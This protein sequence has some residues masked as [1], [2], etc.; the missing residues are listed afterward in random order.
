MAQASEALQRRQRFVG[1]R[2]LEE[3]LGLA[4]SFLARYA[5]GSWSGV[6]AGGDTPAEG[7][8][9]LA[10]SHPLPYYVRGNAVK[11]AL[12]RLAMRLRLRGT[13]PAGGC[14]A[15][16]AEARRHLA[17]CLAS[18]AAAL[19]RFHVELLSLL[20]D[21]ADLRQLATG[22]HGLAP[23]LE[24]YGESHEGRVEATG[25]KAVGCWVTEVLEAHGDVLAA[26]GERLCAP[27]E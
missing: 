9:R 22:L 20:R 3:S 23:D 12:T 2:Q 1:E 4:R 21:A 19:P 5:A 7:S 16:A 18:A 6:H 10:P 8:W 14:G 26:Y 17:A 13:E 25:L 11:Q 27:G 24:A 15:L